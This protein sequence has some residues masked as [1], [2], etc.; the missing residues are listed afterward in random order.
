MLATFVAE[1]EFRSI[2][3]IGAGV[4]VT[5]SGGGVSIKVVAVLSLHSLLPLLRPRPAAMP[6]NVSF[7]P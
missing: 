6:R 5:L 1:A 3:G 2:V 7:L 4:G